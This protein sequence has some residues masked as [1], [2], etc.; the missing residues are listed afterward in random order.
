[1]RNIL[2][3]FTTDIKRIGNNVVA[4]VVIMGLSILP[5]LYAWFNIFSNWDPYEPA[6]TSQLKVAVASDDVGENFFGISVNVGDNVLTALEANT[7]IGWVFPETTAEAMEGVESSEYYAA[8]IIPEG[9]TK[10]MLGFLDGEA[11]H[12]TIYYYENEKKNGIAPKITGK[13]K[14]AVQEQVNATFI[15]TL[16]E[17]VMKA[18]NALSMVDSD[19]N[20]S[21]TQSMSAV[22]SELAGY[23]VMLQSF[24]SIMNSAEMIMETSQAMLPNMDDMLQNGRAT[25]TSMQSMMY[26]SAD[27]VDV[28]SE[29]VGSSMDMVME[30]LQY[31]SV[32]TDGVLD[33]I[34]DTGGTSDVGLGMAIGLVE[35][36]QANL[37]VLEKLVSGQ[38]AQIA[39]IGKT[40]DSIENDLKN[41]QSSKGQITTD[42]NALR[43]QLKELI[44]I[45]QT[46]LDNLRN[47]YNYNVRPSFRATTRS[48]QQSFL[49]A[50]AMMN[51]TDVNMNEVSDIL[52][53]YQRTIKEGTASLT[54]SLQI[55]QEL[56]DKLTTV[57]EGIGKMTGAESYD[58]I[59]N[60]MATDPQFLAEF[61]S[62]PVD[63]ETVP[64][65]PVDHY[66]SAASPFY[67]ILAIWVGALF[68][69]AIIHVAVKPVESGDHYKTYE[70]YFG[71]YLLFFIVGQVQTLLTILG[72]LYYIQI[73]CQHPFLYWLAAAVASTAFSCFMY[74]VTF[75]FGNVGEAL[76][77]VVMVIQVAG[78][79]GTFP[80]ET[81]PAVFQ[82][83]YK[84][85]PFQ[86][87]M[88]AFKECIAGMY[89]VDYWINV[90]K[91]GIFFGVSL[92]IGLALEP[93]FRKLNHV[94]EKSKEKT[95]LMI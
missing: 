88:K 71:R 33:N 64:I 52:E 41:L 65:Y 54:E 58:D 89:G 29:M 51:G 38:D 84:F 44:A 78:S 6:A 77:I 81:L 23:L 14:T 35:G 45:C 87:G 83:V 26:A 74:S 57:V 9:F 13:A 61:V 31:L 82:A 21:I 15:S 20:L 68:L 36:M 62:S 27:A 17:A 39:E 90:G 19:G 63:L 91:L 10:E 49:N 67:T 32:F 73:Q 24:Q 34:S 79:G 86:F 42:I 22:Q 3:I 8:L 28:M 43:S 70:R 66:G 53:E 76:A 18:G 72:N 30:A 59:L 25:M 4:V 47:D 11:D 1:M 37:D 75:A 69:V 94:I 56:M 40:L 50:A 92:L 80:I 95:G 48:M 16:A 2:K 85:L 60:A 55:G 46:Q 93:P 12:P 7:T 5:A